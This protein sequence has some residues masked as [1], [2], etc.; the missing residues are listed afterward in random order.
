VNL[1]ATV[2]EFKSWITQRGQTIS[3]DTVDDITIGIILDSVCRYID[4]ET[5][6][7]FF[8]LVQTQLYDI[9]NVHNWHGNE[10]WLT[11]DLLSLTTFTNGDGTVISSSDYV[12]KS[13]NNPPYWSVGLRDTTSIGWEQDANGSNQQ[14]L[15][16]AGVWGYHDQYTTRAWSIGDTLK[17]AITDITG[18]TF[19]TVLSGKILPDMLVKIDSEFFN[20]ASVSQNSG[21]DTVTVSAR[22]EN[23]STAA[24]H[25]I[26]ATIYIWNVMSKIKTAVLTIAQSM[27]QERSGQV[28]G[29]KITVTAGGVVIRPEDVPPMAQKII[30]D[31]RRVS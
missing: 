29:G 5:L 4:G 17:A 22:G 30:D 21:G 27:Y 31:N 18:L 24:T 8:P 6:R 10:I 28:S 1:Y 16:L 2:A 23:G 11:D 13:V 7:R 15:S 19:T 20:V 9:P 25:I 12:L 14:V 3:S 26:G